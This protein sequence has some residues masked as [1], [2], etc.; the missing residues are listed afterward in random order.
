MPYQS[1][2]IHIN[3]YQSISDI[4]PYSPIF[5]HHIDHIGT[6][7][8]TPDQF[9]SI[10]VF[11]VPVPIPGS[12]ERAMTSASSKTEDLDASRPASSRN[13]TAEVEP[14]EPVQVPMGCPMG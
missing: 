6:F 5:T 10:Y 4:N 13:D 1:I 11:V 7:L 2:S 3:P 14:V 9:Q 12:P 8:R